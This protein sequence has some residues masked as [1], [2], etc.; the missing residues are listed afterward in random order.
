[1]SCRNE[2]RNI[3]INFHKKVDAQFSDCRRCVG[4]EDEDLGPFSYQEHA[5][6]VLPGYESATKETFENL[7]EI[8][9]GTP[10]Y[11]TDIG[12]E[13]NLDKSP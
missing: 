11:I 7:P 12:P 1:M 4:E 3:F 2:L 8:L 5:N 10:D 6:A 9:K 13:P